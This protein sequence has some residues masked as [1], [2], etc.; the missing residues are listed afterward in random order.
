M[1]RAASSKSLLPKPKKKKD[2]IK[3]FTQ[4]S[5]LKATVTLKNLELFVPLDVENEASR[6]VSLS[7]RT[8]CSYQSAQEHENRMNMK[9][10]EMVEQIIH[11]K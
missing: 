2:K 8:L 4:R 3:S 5:A 9:T 1:L 10:G 7:F 11:R 6:V